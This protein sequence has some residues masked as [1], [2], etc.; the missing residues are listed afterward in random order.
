M[1]NTLKD[2]VLSLLVITAFILMPHKINAVVKDICAGDLGNSPQDKENAKSICE[3]ICH[4]PP[5]KWMAPGY[6][7]GRR[8]HGAFKSGDEAIQTCVKQGLPGR[9]ACSCTFPD[10][11]ETRYICAGLLKNNAEALTK[12]PKVCTNAPKVQEFEGRWV[13]NDWKSDNTG[14]G[15]TF[16]NDICKN[17]TDPHGRSICKCIFGFDS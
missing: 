14:K 13:V 11:H 16:A 5:V 1:K 4:H 9:S 6:W 10:V 17:S 15:E 12:C 8:T 7:E 2:L 3:N